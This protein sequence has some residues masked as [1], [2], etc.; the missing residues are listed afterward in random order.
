MGLLPG[1]QNLY[2]MA[3]GSPNWDDEVNGAMMALDTLVQCRFSDFITELPGSPVE[4]AVYIVASSGTTGDLVGREGQIAAYLE[5]AWRYFTPQSGWLAHNAINRRYYVYRA[6]G[7]WTAQFSAGT[8]ENRPGASSDNYGL[9]YV[10]TDTGAVFW[11]RA[12]NGWSLFSSGYV[13]GLLADRPEASEYQVGYTY[14][15]LDDNGGT[16]YRVRYNVDLLA[17]EWRQQANSVSSAGFVPS[18]PEADENNQLLY[19]FNETGGPLVNHGEAVNQTIPTSASTPAYDRS[20]NGLFGRCFRFWRDGDPVIGPGAPTTPYLP[21][22][23]F[24]IWAWV[25]PR[26]GIAPQ[27]SNIFGKNKDNMADNMVMTVGSVTTGYRFAVNN[28]AIVLTSRE[29]VGINDEQWHLVVGT[30]DGTSE[31]KFYVDG[32]L[33]DSDTFGGP[34]DDDDGKWSVGA[35][36][37]STSDFWRGDIAACGIDDVARDQSYIETMFKLGLPGLTGSS[38]YEYSES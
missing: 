23:A 22:G 25:R 36:T 38:V 7:V 16:P 10:A 3:A 14:F 11:N 32:R 29:Y 19:L 27:S 4:G 2:T 24:T 30:W 37:Q 8:A 20:V 1:L 34:L 5:G 26:A 18:L 31:L 35:F 21:S 15:A 33:E 12:G 17:Y 6:N 9:F 13:E 28:D